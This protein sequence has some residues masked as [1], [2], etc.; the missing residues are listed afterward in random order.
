MW[1]LFF[2]LGPFTEKHFGKALS[3]Q[4]ENDHETEILASFQPI[5]NQWITS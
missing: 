1:I 3:S 2:L 5:T 4:D